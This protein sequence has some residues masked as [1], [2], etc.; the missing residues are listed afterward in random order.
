MNFKKE[1]VNIFPK[2]PNWINEILIKLNNN[3]NYVYGRKYKEYRGVIE[4]NLENF[5]NTEKLLKIVNYA[6]EKVPYYANYPK[7]SSI[8]EFQDKISFIDR[9]VISDN[10][11]SLQSEE[12]I[13][14]KFDLVTTGGTTGKP[15]KLLLPKNRFI[16]EK[17]TVHTLWKNVGFNHHS[18]AVLRNHKIPMN[19]IF[20]VNPITKEYLFDGFRLDDNYFQ[21]VYRIIKQKKIRY[22]HAYP[23][24]AYAFSKFIDKFNLDSS[25][26]RAFISS[27]ENVY[28]YQK[29]FIENIV[30]IKI[31]TF[32]GHSE[33]IIIGGYCTHNDVYHMEPTYGYFELIDKK[34]EPITEIG[35]TGE[36]VGTSLNNF[37]M[38]L[39]RYKTDD[40]A[41]YAGDYCNHCKRRIPL[42]KNVSGRW[43]G[44]KIYGADGVVTTPTALNFHNDLFVVID[45]LQYVQEKKGELIVKIVKG[46]NFSSSYEIKIMDHYKSKLSLGT[47]I[48]IKYVTRIEKQPNGKFL[49]LIS[50]LN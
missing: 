4:N 33:K 7:I 37:G 23:S 10:F 38:P 50:K 27:S 14:D 40:F 25:I 3:P 2:I 12:I 9:N 29:D 34:G 41:E 15:L 22:I 46:K 36:I 8:K 42:L 18:R 47:K 20:N 21:E 45:G 32:F 11:K 24:N 26:V 43:S 1:L 5:D 28:D 39:I 44:R 48:E 17:A 49:D 35:R 6:I 30:G 13:P 31:F 19:K 16:I